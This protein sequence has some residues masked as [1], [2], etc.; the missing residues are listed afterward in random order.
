MIK[1]I[2]TQKKRH[3]ISDHQPR[4]LQTPQTNT[5]PPPPPPHHHH[6]PRLNAPKKYSQTTEAKTPTKSSNLEI[7]QK[8]VEQGVLTALR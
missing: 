6:H 7:I 4:A 1:H 2:R 5:Q 3:N 8:V